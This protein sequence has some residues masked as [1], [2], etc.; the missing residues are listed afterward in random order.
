MCTY[1]K[2]LS[3]WRIQALEMGGYMTLL[4]NSHI[5][6]ISNDAVCDTISQ[7]KGLLEDLISTVNNKKLKWYGQS[8]H[9]HL[10]RF[11]LWPKKQQLTEGRNELTTEWTGR[12]FRYLDIGTTRCS[13]T[14]PRYG[15]H[16]IML[17]LKSLGSRK[18]TAGLVI[19]KPV[20]LN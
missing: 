13:A 12:L 10:A 3:K 6:C 15:G 4:D 9:C 14:T 7:E 20:F 5:N 1:C 11:N 19:S 2:S 18:W 16:L 8:F 17:S